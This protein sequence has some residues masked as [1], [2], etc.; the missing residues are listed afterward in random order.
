MSTVSSAA[1]TREVAKHMVVL[2]EKQTG[3]RMIA[4]TTVAEAI[5]TSAGWL[6][7]FISGQEAK[8]PGWTTGWNILDQYSRICS[9]VEAAIETE[10]ARTLAL[11]GMIDAANATAHRMVEAASD[12]PAP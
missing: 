10:R 11:K 3:S 4:Y 2:V 6:R 7:K 5:G 12:K 8:E 1:F 9:R